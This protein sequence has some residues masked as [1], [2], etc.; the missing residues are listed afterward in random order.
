MG[1]GD[2][3]ATVRTEYLTAAPH[4]DQAAIAVRNTIDEHAIVR[5][6]SLGRK[7]AGYTPII[8]RFTSPTHEVAS[9]ARRGLTAA[10][11]H[12]PTD[13]ISIK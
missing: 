9:H 7:R 1:V 4:P 10:R 3:F 8:I 2:K 13:L 11:R 12:G 6:W 5:D